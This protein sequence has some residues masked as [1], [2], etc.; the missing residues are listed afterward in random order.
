MQRVT[1]SRSIVARSELQLLALPAEPNI[2]RAVELVEVLPGRAG[3]AP[4]HVVVM[5]T[6][7]E[8]DRWPERSGAPSSMPAR[9]RRVE[10]LITR[11]AKR[12]QPFVSQIVTA[13]VASLTAGTAAGSTAEIS[14]GKRRDPRD[15]ENAQAVRAVRRESQR[16]QTI[17]ERQHFAH[18]A[19]DL[20][21]G[22]QAQQSAV[23]VGESELA[24][25]AQHAR[26]STSA[27]RGARIST[28][29]R[30]RRTAP[31]R[32]AGTFMPAR[33]W[34]RQ[35][36]ESSSRYLRPL[37][38]AELSAFGCFDTSRTSPTTTPLT[39]ARPDR[40]PRL[41]PDMVKSGR[42]RA[43]PSAVGEGAQP[44]SELHGFIELRK[45]THVAVEEQAKVVDAVRSMV[46]R[47]RP[48]PKA[49]PM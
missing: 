11:P 9:R 18:V 41:S 13:N 43:N 22:R 1:A 20:S 6:S 31:I 44:R 36:M 15:A 33:R 42:A 47:S 3:Q 38:Q 5:S 21:L 49:K 35:T 40:T 28:T 34:V 45:E 27:H 17:V 37:A 4:H 12:P 19:T 39:E 26:L 14:A 25:R 7:A 16:K 2:D 10:F 8:I 48:E 30:C 46:R 24:R 29:S 23:I 32:A